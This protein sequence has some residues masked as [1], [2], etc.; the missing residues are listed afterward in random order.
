MR[1]QVTVRFLRYATLACVAAVSFASVPR[2]AMA[3]GDDTALISLVALTSQRLALATPVARWKWQNHRAITDPEREA[4]LLTD[5]AS[6]APAQNVDPAFARVFFQ[7]QIEA[8]KVVQNALFERWRSGGPPQEPAPDLATTTRPELDRLTKA[9][10]VALARVA[11][12]RDAADCPT[13]LARSVDH[14][15]AVTRYDATEASAL[16]GAL[17]HV[18]TAGSVGGVG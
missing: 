11:P 16:P 10:L 8:S 2:F 4:A 15:K 12:L 9:L 18:C 13:R 1:D 3:D 7:D 14:W 6:R 5:V 17:S